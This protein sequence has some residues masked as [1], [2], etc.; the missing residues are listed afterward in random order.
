M[1]FFGQKRLALTIGALLAISLCALVSVTGEIVAQQ[2]GDTSNENSLPRGADDSKSVITWTPRSVTVAAS[3]GSSTTIS[4]SFVSSENVQHA[5]IIVSSALSSF[6]TAQPNSLVDVRKGEST[7][8][9]ILVAPPIGA[10]L[11]TSTGIITLRKVMEKD[12]EGE[13]GDDDHA[14]D[15]SR[16]HALPLSV[17]VQKG[18]VL[19]TPQ[20]FQIDTQTLAL[21]GPVSLDN[22]GHHYQQGGFVPPGGAAI[23]ITDI[24]LPKPPLNNLIANELQGATI[25]STSNI[26]VSGGACTEE[27]YT[28]SYG[29]SLT[30][31][32]IAVYCPHGKLLYK[33]YLSYRAGDDLESQFLTSFQ[34]VLN[35]IQFTQ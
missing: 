26:S 3:P 6:V 23:D 14:P 12:E 11:G 22:F 25:T 7:T 28:D 19:D 5:L 9:H 4:V 18:L 10:S 21:G 8:L 30:Y 27:F 16:Y 15:G 32:N 34:Q 17:V 13:G 2:R 35:T 20:N 24:P 33:L 29:P 1:N 31:K